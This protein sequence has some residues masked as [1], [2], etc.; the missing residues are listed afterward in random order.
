MLTFCLMWKNF[1]L[2]NNFAES[3]SL[4]MIVIDFGLFWIFIQIFF[5]DFKHDKENTLNKISF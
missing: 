2:C 3:S 4:Q 5:A 1:L